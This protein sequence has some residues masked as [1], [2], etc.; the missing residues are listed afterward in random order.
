MR[1]PLFA[2]GLL[3]ATGVFAA[4]PE[5]TV[6]QATVQFAPN[7]KVEAVQESQVPG[8]YEAIVGGEFVYVC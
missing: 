4:T 3:L 7:V 6:R 8:F 1:L 5:E 2:T